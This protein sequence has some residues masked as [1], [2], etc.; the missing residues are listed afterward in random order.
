MNAPQ[1]PTALAPDRG[2]ASQPWRLPSGGLIDRSRAL[3]FTFDGRRLTGHPGDTLA[4]ALLANGV[5]LVGRS[6]KYHRPRGILSAGPEEPNALVELR[7]G[8]RR[9]PN[10][11]ATQ[12][13][14]FDGLVARSQN[15]WPSLA[16]DLRAVNALFGPLIA[17]GFYYK[18]FMWPASF[19]EKLYEPL[20]RRAAGLGRA[21][22]GAD[23]DHYE[24]AHLH[25]DVL[26]VGGG[27][28]GL[29]AALAAGR[30]GARVLLLEEDVALGGRLLAEAEEVDGRP[31]SAWVRDI[32]AEL[33]SL[34]R[35]RILR[36]TS[37]FAL[38]DGGV[39]AA[40]ER[41]A[42]HL[43][44]PPAYL[45][46]QRYW[47]I[48]A[49]RVVLA[50][51]AIERPV[52]FGGNDRPGV[53]LAG[54]VRAYLNRFAVLPGRRAV[55]FTAGDDGWRSVADLARAGARIEAVVD[56]RREVPEAHAA[57]AKRLGARLVAGGRVLGTQGG[58]HL[59]SVRFAD[60]AGREDGAGADLL[61]VSGGWN[62]SVQLSCHLGGRPR[63][64]E[65]IHAFVPGDL[66]PGMSVAGA[67]SGDLS[68]HAALAGGAREGV[69]AARDCGFV[70]N[71]PAIPRAEDAPGDLAPLFHVPSRHG[72]AFVDF[73]HDVTDRDVALAH[74]EGFRSVEHLKRYTTLGMATDQGKTANVTGLAVMANITGLGIPGSGTT[75]ARPPW[76][77]VAIGAIA[78]PHRGRQF[79]PARRT[80][81]HD[82]AAAN[83]ASFVEVGPW[84]RA[85]WYAR[86][87]EAG[88]RDSV[89]R[90]ALAVRSAVGVC[91]VSTLGKIEAVGPGAAA[92][93]DLVYANT[94]STLA[95]GRVRYG[96]ML[97]EDGFVMD[98]GTVARLA[99]DRFFIT[100]TTANAGKVMQ[101][102]EFCHQVL[103]PDLDVSLLSVT[104]AWAQLS[105]AGPRARDLVAAVVDPGPDLSNAAL[106]HM[107]CAE[108][109][110]DGVPARLYRLSFSGELAYELGVPA[111]HGEATIRRIMERG[112]PLGV[113]P[114]GTEAL[115]VL[116][117]EKGHPAG[118]ELNG[119]TT[120][121]DLGLGK[122]VSARKDCI[123]R[124]LA[125]RPAL[126]DP[127]RPVLVG[128]KPVDRR[129]A[130]RAGAHLFTP[131]AEPVTSNDEGH[132]TSACY[133][134]TLGHPIA[135][136]L[137]ARGA[138]RMGQHIRVLDPVRGG[139]LE[140][141]ICSP[142]FVD[143][144]GGRTRG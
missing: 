132:V 113:T 128:L 111:D 73:Q 48:V 98:D 68:T 115:S 15:R 91:D 59:A 94:L 65:A 21:P 32:E 100:T 8:A 77:P 64:D 44:E 69:A 70:S 10:T 57:L 137:L 26:V 95:E 106:P 52:V 135:L 125:E 93:L 134:P 22:E 12:A 112:A 136:A 18:T 54:A 72:K 109:T 123:G 41:V 7:S 47:K 49:R 3:A 101:H 28:T 58:R 13:E 30:A 11:R 62:P 143:P 107:A 39:V 56:A 24:R 2:I 121:R 133:S 14:L 80:P 16:F 126:T 27:P 67:A 66:P 144:E 6:F 97:R 29:M 89:D 122:L 130:I 46:R 87:G 51:G 71:G 34:P 84:Y 25:C 63:W 9:E 79:R 23:P 114:Y 118:G 90:E 131:G 117:I 105:I 103:R 82:W 110:I 37:A 75:T 102:M 1:K 38:L 86:S 119:Q 36:R 40:V 138:E 53:M 5:R 108:V 99:P 96:L 61:A 17:A 50:A 42:D 140:A 141:E 127:A 74:R 81:L 116:R 45:P 104:D 33:A 120:A 129:S 142:V 43:P 92:L 85:Q 4:S 124:R 20:I 55:V 35:L 139:D 78:G 76:T 88:W 31:A 19:W 60:A 83:G